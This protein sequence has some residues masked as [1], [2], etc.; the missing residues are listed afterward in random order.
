MEI[1]ETYSIYGRKCWHT[2]FGKGARINVQAVVYF[3][4]GQDEF[5]MLPQIYEEAMQAVNKGDCMPFLMAGFISE[6]WNDDYSP[7]PGEAVF[8]KG[9]AFGG[10][11]GETLDWLA[12]SMIPE[13]EKRLGESVMR[14]AVLG[15]SLAGL[16]ALWCLYNADIFSAC[17]SCSGSLWYPGWEKY[18]KARDINEMDRLYISL[19]KK[20]EKTKNRVMA[21]VGENTR[22]FYS[23]VKATG[24][25]ENIRLEWNEGGHFNDVATRLSK[26]V[27]WLMG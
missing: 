4:C 25:T 6:N 7:W 1:T 2:Y 23:Y 20:E 26:A 24:K 10:K 5:E 16:F 18:F 13:A 9:G 27:T 3:A 22:D 21:T 11:A 12:A 15:Y 17:G 14:R 8:P 19:G